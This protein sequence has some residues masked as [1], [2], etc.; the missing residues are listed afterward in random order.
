MISGNWLSLIRP[1]SFIIIS[2]RKKVIAMEARRGDR[3]SLFF[4]TFFFPPSISN[5]KKKKK[6]EISPGKWTIVSCSRFFELE[7]KVDMEGEK[8]RERVFR[9]GTSIHRAKGGGRVERV[10][11]K[12]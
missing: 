9:S 8:G 11:D 7:G 3:V 10:A 5:E 1:N 6:F 4:P 2:A 12:S